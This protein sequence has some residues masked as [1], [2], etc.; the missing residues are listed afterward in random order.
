M[1]KKKLY[2]MYVICEFY[3]LQSRESASPLGPLTSSLTPD[4]QHLTTTTR[5]SE[6]EELLE[7]HVPIQESVSPRKGHICKQSS[8]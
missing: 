6:E 5:A 4:V 1:P 7:L 8:R 3:F 2:V